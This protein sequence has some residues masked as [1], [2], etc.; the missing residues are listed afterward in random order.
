MLIGVCGLPCG[1]S[2]CCVCNAQMHVISTDVRLTVFVQV[3]PE[4]IK[5][6]VAEAINS[7]KEQLLEER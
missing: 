3:T 1:V 5:A 2:C 4:Q 7:K 6:A